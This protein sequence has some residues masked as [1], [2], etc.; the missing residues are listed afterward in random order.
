METIWFLFGLS[1]AGKN[2][3][4]DL[5]ASKTGW[6]VYHADRDLSPEMR[7]ALAQKQ[8]FTN[9]MRDDYFARLPALIRQHQQAGLPLIVTQGAYKQRHRDVLQQHLP[10]IRFIWVDA[11]PEMILQRLDNRRQGIGFDSAAALLR[12]FEPPPEGSCVVVHNDGDSNRILE[13]LQLQMTTVNGRLTAT[14]QLI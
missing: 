7:L 10:H 2:Y 1:G 3:V 14:P 8:P 13:Q 5:L 4:G 9:A 12:D 11:P 6:P